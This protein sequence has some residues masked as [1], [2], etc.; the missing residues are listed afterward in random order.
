MSY[1]FGPVPAKLHAIASQTNTTAPERQMHTWLL[2]KGRHVNIGYL[3]G[4]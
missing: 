4:S 2:L 3:K 1:L